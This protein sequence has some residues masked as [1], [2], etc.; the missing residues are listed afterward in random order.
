MI[1]LTAGGNIGKKYAY[2]LQKKMRI[3]TA[4]LERNLL[5]SIKM[6]NAQML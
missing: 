3:D 5:I 6:A 2:M 4:F 1:K